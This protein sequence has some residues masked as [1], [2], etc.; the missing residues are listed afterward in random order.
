VGAG[1]EVTASLSA[2]AAVAGQR[3]LLGE[4]WTGAAPLRVRMAV[5]AGAAERAEGTYLGPT[6]NRTAR[7]LVLGSGGQVLCSQARFPEPRA[8]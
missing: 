2:A 8:R 6:L 7:L 5:H 4:H 3:A 1:G